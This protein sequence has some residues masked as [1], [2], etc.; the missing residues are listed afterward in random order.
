MLQVGGHLDFAQEPF[1]T[2]NRA[3]VGFEDLQCD[4]AIVANIAGEL[5]GRHSAFANEAFDEVA[6]G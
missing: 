2:D 1:H 3:E 5:D 4:L 6:I